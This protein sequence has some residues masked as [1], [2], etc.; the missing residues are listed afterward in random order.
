M[1]KATYP[2]TYSDERGSETLTFHNDGSEL[3]TTIRGVFFS[4]TDFDSL[5]PAPEEQAEHLG[6]FTLHHGCLCNCRLTVEIPIPLVLPGRVEMGMLFAHLDLGV[7]AA[8]GGITHEILRL[9]FV[10]EELRINGSVTGSDVFEDELLAIQKQLPEG[11]HLKAC[12]N[13]L[14]SDY[15]P[16]GNG[17]FGTMS[18]FRN[19]KQEYLQVRAK[20]DSLAIEGRA[21]RQVQETFLCEQFALRVPGTG[22]RG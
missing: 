7:P 22:Y 12:I 11:V 16:L 8:H 17:L 19:I 21:E 3:S 13:C 5:E 18:C 9:T 2:G 4:S 6:P 20:Y 14:Y 1:T 15:S 10:F